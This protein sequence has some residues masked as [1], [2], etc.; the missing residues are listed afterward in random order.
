MALMVGVLLQRSDMP[1]PIARLANSAPRQRH[2]G[3][4]AAV[5]A[6]AAV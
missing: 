4:L 1:N 2:S 5:T 3:A 6:F